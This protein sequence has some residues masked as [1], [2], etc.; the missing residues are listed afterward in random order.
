MEQKEA[1]LS[2]HGAF[3]LFP[4]FSYDA[5]QAQYSVQRNPSSKCTFPTTKSKIIKWQVLVI[6][7]VNGKENA[8]ESGLIS[9]ILI[10][11]QSSYQKPIVK[12]ILS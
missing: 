8:S 10:C 1:W 4:N 6:H 3:L 5:K 2:G 9:F 12:M 7:C 11:S